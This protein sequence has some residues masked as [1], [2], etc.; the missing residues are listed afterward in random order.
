MKF[1]LTYSTEFGS[2]SVESKKPGDLVDGFNKVKRVALELKKHEKKSKVERHHKGEV[3]RTDRRGR[4]ETSSILTEIES[5]L[6][7]ASFFSVPR[8]TGETSEKLKDITGTSYTSRKISQALG[9][10][11]KNR[12]LKRTGR[13]NSFRYS[14]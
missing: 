7:P 12:S 8:T 9:I 6:I 13:R 1:I 2:I 3:S 4:G 10:L 14:S 5:K 11:W